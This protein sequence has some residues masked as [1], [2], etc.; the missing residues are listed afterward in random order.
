[1][2]IRGIILAAGKSSRMGEN[3]LQLKI[4]GSPM[5][6]LVI[7]NAKKSRLDELV[8]VYGK[9]DLSTDVKK[10]FNYD[11]EKGMSTSI[12][13]GLKGFKGDGV[14]LL[15]ADMPFIETKVIDEL[16]TSFIKS[17][18]NIVVPMFNGKKGNPVIIGSKYF[19]ELMNNT[20]DK[21]ARDII[22]RYQDDVE[23]V[24]VESDRIFMDIDN[25]DVYNK[26]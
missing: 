16:Y 12:K 6:E 13:C 15:L 9:Y 24:E 1:M 18:K 14:M 7:Q 11:Y 4:S 19:Q 22:K 20:G 25:M 8:I 26:I 21:G 17:D 5:V 2:Y 10:L 3:K 23:I